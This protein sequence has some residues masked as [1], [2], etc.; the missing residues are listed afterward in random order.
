[1]KPLPLISINYSLIHQCTMW[2]SVTDR[3]GEGCLD[4][5]EKCAAKMQIYLDLESK[6]HLLYVSVV[7]VILLQGLQLVVRV[8]LQGLHDLDLQNCHVINNRTQ[9]A[10]GR[11]LPA[12]RAGWAG[13]SRQSPRPPSLGSGLSALSAPGEEQ[14]NGSHRS[15]YYKLS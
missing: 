14:F 15:R 4:S 9:A 1:M 5:I 2:N 8:I 11:G 6:F 3:C 13:S 7:E 12:C 10:P